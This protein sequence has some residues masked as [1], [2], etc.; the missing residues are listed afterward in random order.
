MSFAMNDIFVSSFPIL[1]YIFNFLMIVPWI[2]LPA[3]Y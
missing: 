3:E 1:L 2:E